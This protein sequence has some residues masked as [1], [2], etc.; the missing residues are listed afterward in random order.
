MGMLPVAGTCECC[1]SQRG[2]CV[3]K[4]NVVHSR[5]APPLDHLPPDW[6]MTEQYSPSHLSHLQMEASAMKA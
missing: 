2:P 6:F 4:L 1:N 3:W 5:P